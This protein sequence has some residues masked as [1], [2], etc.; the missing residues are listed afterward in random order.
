MGIAD[1]GQDDETRKQRKQAQL[2]QMIDKMKRRVKEGKIGQDEGRKE[3]A[4]LAKAREALTKSRNDAIDVESPSNSISNVNPPSTQDTARIDRLRSEVHFSAASGFADGQRSTTPTLP[5]PDRRA[6]VENVSEAGVSIDV[7]LTKRLQENKQRI[8]RYQEKLASAG[9]TERGVLEIKIQKLQNERVVLKAELEAADSKSSPNSSDEHPV[10]MMASIPITSKRSD[11]NPFEAATSAGHTADHRS[12]E[13]QGRK[14]AEETLEKNK[15]QILLASKKLGPA[16]GGEK[17]EM[18]KAL[19]RLQQE[20]ANLQRPMV[21]KDPD[22]AMRRVQRG[23]ME[24]DKDQHIEEMKKPAQTTGGTSNGRREEL[25]SRL[26]QNKGQLVR[27]QQKTKDASDSQRPDIE[28]ALDQLEKDRM[29]LK[30]MMRKCTAVNGAHLPMGNKT[31]PRTV[32]V[33][34]EEVPAAD[35]ALDQDI[36]KDILAFDIPISKYEGHTATERMDFPEAA[37][38]RPETS[39]MGRTPTPHAP[40]SYPWAAKAAPCAASGGVQEASL[41]VQKV[42]GPPT[43]AT[44]SPHGAEPGAVCKPEGQTQISHPR[45]S[46]RMESRPNSVVVTDTQNST[47]SSCL[48]SLATCIG[49]L[50]PF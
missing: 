27:L 9:G 46:R 42:D 41:P 3:I 44:D 19:K 47:W 18:E 21:P 15:V 37:D 17:E 26:K 24:K 7:S 34:D 31:D 39:D 25:E 12:L 23:T 33:E 43:S 40:G 32:T 8:K 6:R 11:P 50:I 1:G 30:R 28:K 45:L 20:R 29:Q 22:T 5:I 38:I 10:P 4:K 16:T 35:E 14:D 48:V 2:D 13:H 49:M 36:L